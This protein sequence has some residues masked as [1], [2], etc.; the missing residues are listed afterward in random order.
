MKINAEHRETRQ[1]VKKWTGDDSTEAYTDFQPKDLRFYQASD[2]TLSG[3]CKN[4]DP[5]KERWPS[6]CNKAS[7]GEFSQWL[8]KSKNNVKAFSPSK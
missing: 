4:S 3:H 7:V 6:R 1:S 8:T 2:L 5:Y